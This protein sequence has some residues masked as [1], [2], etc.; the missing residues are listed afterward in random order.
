MSDPAVGPL[1]FRR[2]V[3]GLVAALAGCGTVGDG[4][5]STVTD[6]TASPAADSPAI[7]PRA[8]VGYTHVR[9]SGNRLATAPGSVPDAEPVDVSLPATPEWVVGVPDGDTSVWVAVLRDGAVRGLRVGGG[10]VTELDEVTVVGDGPPLLT[11]RGETV[12]ALATRSLTHPVPVDGGAGV[13]GGDGTLRLPGGALDVGALPDARVVRYDGRLFVYGRATDEYDHGVLGDGAEAGGV[14]VVD[15]EGPEVTAWL[16]PP[17]GTVFEGLAPL[18]A[19]WGGETTVVTTASDGDAGARVVAYAPDGTVR[20]SGPAVGSGFRWRHQIALAPFPAD[21]ATELAAVRTPHIDGT[22]EFY[23][24]DGDGASL[25]AE[26]S[27]YAPHRIGSRNL[28]MAAAGDFD[29]DGRTE[30][31]V[32]DD[33]MRTLA[34]LRRTEGGVAEAWRAPLGG[35]LTTN[36]GVAGGA[37]AV[38]WAD[39]LRIWPSD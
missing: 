13:V 24:L 36:V 6:G 17:D 2:T 35:R 32:P 23:R 37:V 22:V 28:D 33:E 27:G 16:N 15:P 30:L 11:V 1:V 10:S 38:G 5:S 4:G 21:G 34:G 20:A 25:A 14:A 12:R 26:R 19:Q 39:A 31:V 7:D 9:P 3:L 8:S 18:V 29:G